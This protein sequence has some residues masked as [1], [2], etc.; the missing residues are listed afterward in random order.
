ML[1]YWKIEQ[2][3]VEKSAI[4]KYN[5]GIKQQIVCDRKKGSIMK[6][7]A[8]VSLEVRARKYE[9][10]QGLEDGYE[11]YSKVVTNGWVVADGVIQIT[12]PDGSIVCPFILNRR[13]IIFIRE[14]DYIIYEAD[15]ERHVCGGDKFFKRFRALE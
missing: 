7:F 10:G 3:S 14:G 4:L 5:K 9:V 15:G 6:K 8:R 1:Y 11:L 12:K 2:R 13:G